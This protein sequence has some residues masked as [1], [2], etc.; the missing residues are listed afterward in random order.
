MWRVT[1]ERWERTDERLPLAGGAR[2]AGDVGVREETELA[3]EG[4]LELADVGAVTGEEHTLNE[5]LQEYN[6]VSRAHLREGWCGTSMKNWES[7]AL[8]V[9][10]K[11]V[12]WS[13]QCQG[14]HDFC[15]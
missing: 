11:G 1:G 9:E 5:S 2:V 4:R 15:S 10:S 6:C 14:M 13:Q 3:A 7:K 12:P 8:G